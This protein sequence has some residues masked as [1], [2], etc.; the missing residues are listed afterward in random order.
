MLLSFFFL[1]HTT[2]QLPAY[3][4]TAVCF[5]FFLHVVGLKFTAYHL[6]AQLCKAWYMYIVLVV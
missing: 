4:F 1:R 5:V 3:F 2:E 6:C